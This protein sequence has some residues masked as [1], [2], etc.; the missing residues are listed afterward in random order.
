M[1][2]HSIATAHIV[3]IDFSFGPFNLLSV[4]QRITIENMPY[5][6]KQIFSPFFKDR[7]QIV[8]LRWSLGFP[9]KFIDSSLTCFKFMPILEYGRY[10]LYLGMVL[11]CLS[12]S[13][14]AQMK[15]HKTWN[16]MA[17]LASSLKEVGISD[18]DM[19][20]LSCVPFIMIISNSF[21]FMSFKNDHTG[22]NKMSK[23]L[24][25]FNKEVHA[26]FGKKISGFRDRSLTG[27]ARF[28]V[29]W[30]T[31]TVSVVM[32]TICWST[33]FNSSEL[34]KDISNAE[35]T[36]FGLAQFINAACYIYPPVSYSADL[37]VSCL[38]YETK[39]AFDKFELLVRSW[40]TAKKGKNCDHNTLDL[41]PKILTKTQG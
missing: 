34:T 27:Y 3:F 29:I 19:A 32:I 22:W 17:A 7:Y 1:P 31:D 23:S 18:L 8:L 33:I 4:F 6:N 15:I 14:Y 20:V 38:V 40:N 28:F 21:Y 12:Y 2:H 13:V 30:L 10:A 41:C 16:F 11:L 37:V 25:N 36:L 39:E 5:H 9:L 24:S 26:Y 35:K